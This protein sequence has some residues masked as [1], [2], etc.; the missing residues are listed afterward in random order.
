MHATRTTRAG[1]Y[2]VLHLWPAA[3]VAALTAA[4]LVAL[5]LRADA[6][7]PVD[8]PVFSNPTN[9]TNPYFPFTPGAVKV[10]TGHDGRTRLAVVDLYLADTR[11]FMLGAQTVTCRVL[12]ETEFEDG[13]VSEISRNFFAQADD[14]TVWYFGE[15]VDVY[16]DGVVT[17]HPGS[18]LVGGPRAGDPEGTMTVAAPGSFMPGNPEVGDQV[19]PEDLPDGSMEIGTVRKVGKSIRV[20]ALKFTNCIEVREHVLP[21]DEFESKWYAPGVGVVRVKAG[22][23]QLFFEAGTLRQPR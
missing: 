5:S 11:Q 7:A 16:E 13:E 14:G 12:Q 18:W 6:A 10:F 21:D 1:T 23:E 8:P 3:A 2:G 20:P 17:E 4:G 15:T 22:K 19:E 9:F